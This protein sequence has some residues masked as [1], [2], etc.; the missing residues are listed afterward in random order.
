MTWVKLC[1]MTSRRDVEAAVAAG[2]D[3]IGFVAA[4]ASVRSVT[5]GQAAVLG[6]GIAVERY[7]VTVDMEPDRLLAAARL[8]EVDGVQ[9]HGH[10][11]AEAALLLLGAGYRVLFPL[12]VAGPVD[13]SV[14]PPGAIPLLDAAVQG[15]HGGTGVSFDWSL[16]SG[17]GI[18]VVVAGG[19]TPGNVA[20]AVRASGAWGVDTAS[21]VESA[22]GI[23]DPEAMRRFVEAVR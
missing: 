6:A 21:G 18:R 20:E 1:G 15:R 11:A 10:H 9:P 2:A 8:G 5:P 12:R 4:T 7:L 22:P 19:L 17:L 3:A 23:K 14:V 13:L 16:A